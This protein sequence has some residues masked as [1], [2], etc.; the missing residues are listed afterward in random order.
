[1]QLLTLY[2]RRLRLLAGNPR[3]L[4]VPL[5]TPVLFAIVIGPA[6][7]KALGSFDPR[8]DYLTFVSIATVVLL[9]PLNAMFSGLSVFADR[10]HGALRE[11]LAAP[12]PRWLPP[13]A[14]VLATL[15][16]TALQVSV[17]IGAA[18]A[19]GATYHATASGIAWFVGSVALLTMIYAS[20]AEVMAFRLG[21]EQE[22]IGNVP[23][24]AIVP[25]FFAGSLFP[26]SVLPKG[27]AILAKVLPGTHALALMRH[28]L[29]GGSS[30]GLTAIW[31]AR[32]GT[33]AAAASFAIVAA[34]TV[35]LLAMSARVFQRSAVG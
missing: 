20:L 13:L 1:M 11:L 29:T 12:L 3:E 10:E 33:A 32:A 30:D 9:V 21:S 8:V 2:R 31:G 7:K 15:T 14:N 5:A 28:G 16:I 6:L 35:A 26:I 19:R 34:F 24:I 17:L 25:W 27:L 18:V 22:Y 4:I 23:A